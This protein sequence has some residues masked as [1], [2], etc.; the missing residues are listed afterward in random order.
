MRGTW[1]MAATFGA[2]LGWMATPAVAAGLNGT[3]WMGDDCDFDIIELDAH[4]A[5]EI[6]VIIE[7]DE[8]YADARWTVQGAH[9]HLTIP[10]WAE[11]FEGTI[12]GDQL[13]GT[14]TTRDK[15]RGDSQLSCHFT[16][17]G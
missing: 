14:A 6:V 9:L 3:T 8:T 1:L 17:F 11:T 10:E 12:D 7:G 5:A 2:A 16:K 4:S 13:S 15:K